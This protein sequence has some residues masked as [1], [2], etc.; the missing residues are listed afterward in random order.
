MNLQVVQTTSNLSKRSWNSQITGW[1]KVRNVKESKIQNQG[2]EQCQG[3]GH[4]Q[5]HIHVHAQGKENEKEG[6][7]EEKG[8][9]GVK[10]IVEVQK[11][12]VEEEVVGTEGQGD[13]I[14]IQLKDIN[15][16]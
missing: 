9:K 13:I 2:R 4:I 7:K 10:V 12:G 3:Q 5:D 11:G 8:V 15:Q 1:V 14:V 6:A 16:S